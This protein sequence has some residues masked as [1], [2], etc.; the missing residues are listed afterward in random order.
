MSPNWKQGMLEKLR[1]QE[2]KIF[3]HRDKH[4]SEMSKIVG[5][6]LT[7]EQVWRLRQACGAY[8]QCES[9]IERIQERMTNL[10]D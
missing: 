8:E 7:S 9:G 1:E 3:A 2:E 4:E 6:Q 10:G 5:V